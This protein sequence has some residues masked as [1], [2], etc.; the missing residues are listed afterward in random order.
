MEGSAPL[1]R[2][3]FGRQTGLKTLAK[4]QLWPYYISFMVVIY[5][6][7]DSGQYYN[8]AITIKAL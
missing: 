4:V 7:N 3:T 8:T 6:R 2:K 5:N 1:S